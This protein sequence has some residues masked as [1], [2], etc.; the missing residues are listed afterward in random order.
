MLVLNSKLTYWVDQ[1]FFERNP[2]AIRPTQAHVIEISSSYNRNISTVG[3][4]ND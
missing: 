2:V 4:K 1:F 3:Q